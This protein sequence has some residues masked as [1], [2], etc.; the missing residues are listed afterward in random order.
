M[1]DVSEEIAEAADLLD[2]AA[3]VILE[4]GW[5][6]GGL[7]PCHTSPDWAQGKPVCAVGALCVAMDWTALQQ[8]TFLADH[9]RY[10]RALDAL[11]KRLRFS[12]YLDITIWNDQDCRTGEQVTD[13]L[14]DSAKALREKAGAS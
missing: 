3:D 4:H 14:R 1:T 12:N 5:H 8:T 10:V 6:Q 2:R 7:W 13:A 9:P 11:M